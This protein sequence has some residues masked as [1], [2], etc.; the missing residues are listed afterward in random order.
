MTSRVWWRWALLTACAVSQACGE[1]TPPPGISALRDGLD[2]WDWAMVAL[3]ALAMLGIGLYYSRRNKSAE[4][5]Y[6]GGRTMSP[7]MVGLS[8]F[9]T[10]ISTISYLSTPGEI[11]R[12]GPGFLADVLALP[13]SYFI[14]GFLI[15]PYISKLPVTSANEILYNRFGSGV[16]MLGCI[17]FLLIRFIWMGLIIY[18]SSKVVVVAIGLHG[19]TTPYVAC[20]I[21]IVT[22]VY[23]S[24]GGIRAVVLTDAIQAIILFFGVIAAIVIITVKLGGIAWFP[25][26]WAPN[27]DSQPFASYDPRVRTTVVGMI[28]SS[29]TWWICTAG[30]DQMAIQRFMST[31]NPQAARRA[32]LINNISTG[33]VTLLLGVLGFALLGF[34]RANPQ[35]LTESMNLSENADSLFPYF[36]VHFTGYGIAGLIMAGIL[37]AAMSSLSSG[38]NS[39]CTVINTDIVERYFKKGLGDAQRMALAKGT[40]FFVGFSAILLSLVIQNVSGNLL[41]VTSKTSNLLIAPLFGLFFFAMFVRFATPLGAVFGSAYGF[42][43]AFLMAFGDLAGWPPLSWQWITPTALVVDIATGTLCCLIRTQGRSTV[44]KLALCAVY[45]LPLIAVA[46]VFALACLGHRAL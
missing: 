36:I 13:F 32:F 14:V 3:Y 30:A 23:A 21:G 15:I 45:A 11:I 34:F 22:V 37:A 7:I 42:L 6:V 2:A 29:T 8:L 25:T 44:F 4:D 35:Y 18:T 39:T 12:H 31:R 16:R 28:V 43:A 20:A 38:I 24:L 26:Q 27:W 17:I 10:M 19:Q 1:S 46:V 40:S 5:Y 41:E 9:A 33:L